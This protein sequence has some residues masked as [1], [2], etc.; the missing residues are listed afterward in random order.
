MKKWPYSLSKWTSVGELFSL[1]SFFLKP[2]F[3]LVT[4]SFSFFLY[5]FFVSLFFLIFFFVV[6]S[7][8]IGQCVGVQTKRSRLGWACGYGCSRS[9]A[10]ENHKGAKKKKEKKEQWKRKKRTKK[11][12]LKKTS[13][14]RWSWK[15]NFVKL[16]VTP[17]WLF[18][19]L[20]VRSVQAIH[21]RRTVLRLASR[22]TTGRD[23]LAKAA[24]FLVIRSSTCPKTCFTILSFLVF[25][26]L[27]TAITT[28]GRRVQH[29]QGDRA[30][31]NS[32][33]TEERWAIVCLVPTWFCSPGSS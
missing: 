23:D 29:C 20:L 18:T 7:D 3:L 24:C 1:F 21:R 11:A 19:W 13:V 6:K 12:F 9:H 25:S 32:S 26:I 2:F 28:G 22:L 27:S 31:A 16:C 5:F 15:Q 17:T 4:L 33:Q 30:S 10:G 8:F 14:D